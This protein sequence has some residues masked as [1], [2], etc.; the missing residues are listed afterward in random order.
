MFIN[1]RFTLRFDRAQR[2]KFED[3]KGVTKD[4]KSKVRQSKGQKEKDY[5]TNNDLH[6]TT[7]KN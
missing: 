1:M 6:N 3:T 5:R 4:R 2:D 7:Q